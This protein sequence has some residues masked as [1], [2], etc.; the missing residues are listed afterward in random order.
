MPVESGAP[1]LGTPTSVGEAFLLESRQSL[2]G[3]LAKI[4][5]CL[6]QLGQEDVW[7]RPFDEANSIGNIVLH[8]SG[9]VRQWI[10]DALLGRP[11]RRNRAA[12]FSA[13]RQIAKDELLARLRET[14]A[15]ADAAIASFPTSRLL[16]P[17]RMQGFDVSPPVAIYDAVSHL[18]GHTQQIAYITRL[19]LGEQY[20]FQWTP[21][22]EQGG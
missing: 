7:W 1:K 14:L 18:A 16:E 22:K 6:E 9:N 2:Q 12:E 15:D 10:C 4:A 21:T 20:R 5:H 13:R 19:R 11:D 17:L 8:L 3:S